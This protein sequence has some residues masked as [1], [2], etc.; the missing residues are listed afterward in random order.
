MKT[1]LRLALVFSLALCAS[2]CAVGTTRVTITPSP[3]GVSSNQ[4]SG[5]ILV[6]TFKDVRQDDHKYIGNKRNG[7]GIPVGRIGLE[8]GK[9][10]EVMVTG[11]IAQALRH[12][13]YIAVLQGQPGSTSPNA[14]LD[15]EIKSFWM[16]MYMKAWHHID[17]RLTLLDRNGQRVRWQRSV[18]GDESNVL[19]IGAT[20]E[21]ERVINT[22]LDR[23]LNKAAAEFSSEEFSRAARE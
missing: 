15:G 9:E 22:A 13:G 19:W 8:R 10:L 6:R 17:L 21:Y 4:H 2:G 12:A 14:I 1:L 18:E 23:A 20:A 3:L 16:D 5:T 7:F 11:Y